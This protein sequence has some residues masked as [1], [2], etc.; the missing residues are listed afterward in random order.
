LEKKGQIST[1]LEQRTIDEGNT[2]VSQQH[3][4]Q[5]KWKGRAE[6]ETEDRKRPDIGRQPNAITEYRATPFITTVYLHDC[7]FSRKICATNDMWKCL[8]MIQNAVQ[9]FPSW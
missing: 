8:I 5:R 6:K 7:I 4:F 1:R 2:S 9:D 3:R